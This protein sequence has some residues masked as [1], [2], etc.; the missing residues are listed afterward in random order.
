MKPRQ[1]QAPPRLSA[2]QEPVVLPKAAA[3][4]A[5]LSNVDLAKKEMALLEEV[6]KPQ[7]DIE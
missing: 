2:T 4:T 1:A 3:D 5:Q 6:D 7:S